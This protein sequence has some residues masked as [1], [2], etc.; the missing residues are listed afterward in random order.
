MSQNILGTYIQVF[1]LLE[2]KRDSLEKRILGEVAKL[3]STLSI[4][5]PSSRDK[6]KGFHATVVVPDKYYDVVAKFELA[7]NC[8]AYESDKVISYHFLIF[9][10]T[11]RTEDRTEPAVDINLRGP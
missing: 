3:T 4:E 2:I 8:A 11:Y 6:L 10:V 9:L 5:T 1:S 7:D